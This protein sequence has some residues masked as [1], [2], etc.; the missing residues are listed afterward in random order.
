MCDEVEGLVTES[1]K[2]NPRV[3]MAGSHRNKSHRAYFCLIPLA[4]KYPTAFWAFL[5]LTLPS[6]IDSR[7][8]SIEPQGTFAAN[9][10]ETLISVP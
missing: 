7:D 10:P 1:E 2:Q 9:T 4:S 3:L 5:T 6:G 8:A